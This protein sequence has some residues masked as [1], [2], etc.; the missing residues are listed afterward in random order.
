MSNQ[1]TYPALWFLGGVIAIYL[2]L[3]EERRVRGT[4]KSL[5]SYAVE[6]VQK[7]PIATTARYIFILFAAWFWLVDFMVKNKNECNPKRDT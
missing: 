5:L 7:H 3:Q 4:K 6:S 1:Y 2:S